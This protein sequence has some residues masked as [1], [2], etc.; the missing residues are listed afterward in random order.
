M[1]TDN[2][3]NKPKSKIE[4]IFNA[5]LY[6]ICGSILASVLM[7][8][9]SGYELVDTFFLSIMLSFIALF[10][11]M[12]F[13]YLFDRYL[14]KKRGNIVKTAKDRILHGIGFE[15]IFAIFALAFI[16]LYKQ[17]GFVEAMMM[18]AFFL[19]FFLVFTMIFTYLY[20]MCRAF[21]VKKFCH[22]KEHNKQTPY[23]S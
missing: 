16:M 3:Q 2:L 17:I 5:I 8:L 14:I 6:E 20:D 4:L 7:K 1:K 18:E 13:N 22:S 11:N 9:I 15:A 10:W 19:I 21:V 23:L 12:I